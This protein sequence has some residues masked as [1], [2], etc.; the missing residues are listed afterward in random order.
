MNLS[1]AHNQR[2]MSQEEQYEQ[3]PSRSLGGSK[4]SSFLKSAVKSWAK[5]R[6][7]Q[8]QLTGAH[9]QSL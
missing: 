7:L 6:A 3:E 5:P 1:H 8:R 4:H 9:T 2:Q